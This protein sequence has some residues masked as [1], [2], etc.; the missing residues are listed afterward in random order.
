MT[1]FTGEIVLEI[2]RWFYN[3]VFIY[4][5]SE[6]ELGYLA[7][8]GLFALSILKW[9]IKELRYKLNADY[10]EDKFVNDGIVRIA[11]KP[12]M[13]LFDKNKNRVFLS[14]SYSNIEKFDDQ[15]LMISKGNKNG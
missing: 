9:W 3:E 13:G 6:V 11:R 2:D 1:G 4:H 8:S 14:S 15:H 10:I 5:Q 7:M 12:G